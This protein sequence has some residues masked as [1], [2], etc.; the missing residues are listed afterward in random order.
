MAGGV[1]EEKFSGD[2]RR[3]LLSRSEALQFRGR[4][5]CR[6]GGNQYNPLTR[7]L[8]K[9]YT[10]PFKGVEGYTVSVGKRCA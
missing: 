9:R 6:P 8:R 1:L 7:P 10:H 5:K 3:C 2:L 4:Q